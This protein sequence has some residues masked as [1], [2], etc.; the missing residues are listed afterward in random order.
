MAH[1]GPVSIAHLGEH[2]LLMLSIGLPLF[3]TFR[4]LLNRNK[5]D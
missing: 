3:F 2:L 4:Y 5:Q 1:H